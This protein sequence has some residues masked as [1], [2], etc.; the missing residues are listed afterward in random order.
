VIEEEAFRSDWLLQEVRI[1][2]GSRLRL[3]EKNAFYE[4]RSLEPIDVPWSAKIRAEFYV[5]G[6]VYD[7]DG[8]KRTRVHIITL[9]LM[10]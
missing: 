3:V 5:L 7:E 9:E 1:G 4:C 2:T 6:T 10:E 8:S